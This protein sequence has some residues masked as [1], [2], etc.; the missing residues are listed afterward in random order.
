RDGITPAG[1]LQRGSST[2]NAY[3]TGLR[4]AGSRQIS[5]RTLASSMLFN[6]GSSPSPLLSN[7]M[8]VLMN[9]QSTL[10][11]NTTSP[12]APPV[13][14]VA[15]LQLE[16]PRPPSLIRCDNE[17]NRVTV[18]LLDLQ[19]RY[20]YVTV[21]KRSLHAYLKATAV[22]NTEFSILAGPTNIYADNTFIGKVS[23]LEP[24]IKHPEKYDRNKPIRMNKYNNVE[25]DLDLGPGEIRELTLKYSVEHPIN[26]DLD[27]SV[28]EI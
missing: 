10:L 11:P 23:L 28:S 14:T 6:S 9:S 26:E 7:R 12:S 2:E 20:E 27:V 18:G 22:N 15:T 8:S 3:A 19:P 5:R 25:W 16:V 24:T 1:T 4:A 17:P 13:G 21:P